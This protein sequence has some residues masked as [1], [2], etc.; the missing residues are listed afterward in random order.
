MAAMRKHVDDLDEN[1]RPGEELTPERLSEYLDF[2]RS[3]FGA[4]TANQIRAL[5]AWGETPNAEIERLKASLATIQKREA[6]TRSLAPAPD[7][8]P[9]NRHNGR[10]GRLKGIFR[11]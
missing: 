7:P 2:W 1:E 8:S 11:S 3:P 6:G 10:L 4:L 9:P 5:L